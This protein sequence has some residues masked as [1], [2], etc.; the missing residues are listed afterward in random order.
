MRLARRTLVCSRTRLALVL[1]LALGP[2]SARALHADE[3]ED[4]ANEVKIGILY[5]LAKFV[6]WPAPATPREHFALCLLADAGFHDLAALRV[7]DKSVGQLPVQVRKIAGPSE[8]SG[9]QLAFI[10]AA[11]RSALA[12]FR[13]VAAAQAI[14]VVSEADTFEQEIG[15]INLVVVDKRLQLEVD[16]AALAK[17]KLEASSQLLKLAVLRR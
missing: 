15:M 8:A 12:S 16:L 3:V 13:D 2:W 11:H 9:C 10:A 5:N 6:S 14:L 7:K 1:C 17:A 4:R